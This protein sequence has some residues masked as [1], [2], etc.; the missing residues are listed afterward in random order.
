VSVD[1]TDVPALTLLN[2]WADLIAYGG[3]NVENRSWMP[4]DSVWR[5]L[6]H[7][8]KGWAKAADWMPYAQRDVDG[9]TASAIVAVADLAH[10]CRA[11]RWRD[12]VVCGCGKWAQPVQ[13]HWCLGKVW[14]LPE[15][16][17]A[18]GRQGLWRPTPDIRA[19]VEL[20]LGRELDGSTH[21]GYPEVD[22]G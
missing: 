5:L 20:Q 4:P 1:L 19:A 22:R 12:T 10:A 3:K 14:A 15:P 9:V 8:G 11:S 17:P 2:P 21:D 13:C 16:V 6:I 7:A 18:V